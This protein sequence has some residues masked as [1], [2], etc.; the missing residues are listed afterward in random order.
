MSEKSI[1][2]MLELTS[3]G[4]NVRFFWVFDAIAALLLQ[5]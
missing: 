4:K 1:V 5:Q 2:F 3:I